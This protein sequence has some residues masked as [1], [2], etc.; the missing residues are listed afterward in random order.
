MKF[1]QDPFLWTLKTFRQ[2]DLGPF[3]H[4]FPRQPG[5][6]VPGSPCIAQASKNK[7]T[8]LFVVE[9]VKN[10]RVTKQGVFSDPFCE[11]SF[12][13]HH[14]FLKNTGQTIEL[15]IAA[16]TTQENINSHIGTTQGFPEKRKFS[17][18]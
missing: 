18:I 5:H 11:I 14:F 3:L 15:A 10:S 8:Q 17:V 9:W 13:C 2:P 1:R 4:G 7:N 12:F 6:W 16:I